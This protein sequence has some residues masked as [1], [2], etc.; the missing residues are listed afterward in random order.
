[1]VIPD[2][3]LTAGDRTLARR[4]AERDDQRL[5]VDELKAG[6]RVTTR[7]WVGVVRFETV[8]IRII[9]KLAGGNLWLVQMLE[10]TSGLA[11]LRRSEGLQHIKTGADNLF[12][13]VA[14]LLAAEVDR[15]A[16]RGLL[17]DY[18]ER[19]DDLGVIRGRFLVDRQV[20]ERFGRIDRLICRFDDREHDIWEN[21]L[22]AAALAVAER[23]V[24]SVEIGGRLRRLR[25]LFDSICSPAGLDLRLILADREY[26]RLNEHYRGAHEVAR[27]ILD[28]TLVEDILGGGGQRS[29]AFLLD[30]NRLF[31][32]FVGRMLEHALAGTDAV[33]RHQH[34]ETSVIRRADTGKPYARVIPDLLVCPPGVGGTALRGLPVDAKYKLYDERRVDNSDIYQA[35]LYGEAFGRDVERAPSAVLVY[36]TH[37]DVGPT[38]ELEIARGAQGGRAVRILVLGVSIPSALVALRGGRHWA[39]GEKL[40]GAC[41]SA[42]GPLPIP[43]FAWGIHA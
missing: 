16:R 26:H 39:D 37:G 29:F 38:F 28:G 11:A 21:Q 19:E 7:S 14:M 36:P 1:M 2:A 25:G 15:L 6:L 31:E 27:L 42:L 4:F 18:V 30:M 10:L 43:S 17:T 40:R 9:P 8:E 20:L 24:E 22:I 5:G 34:V 41:L 3:A 23:R 13:L 32:L 33:V 35:F 12:D